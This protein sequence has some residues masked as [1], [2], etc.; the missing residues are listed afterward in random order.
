MASTRTAALGDAIEQR[1]RELDVE[2]RADALVASLA[3]ARDRVQE[4]SAELGRRT[5][6]SSR[7]SA[8]SARVALEQ[9][10]AAAW[11]LPDRGDDLAELTRRAGERL[12]RERTKAGRRA[13]RRRRNRLVLIGGGLAGAGLLVGWLTA[14]RRGPAAGQLGRLR[15]TPRTPLDFQT[16]PV[17]VPQDV[18]V[19]PGNGSHPDGPRSD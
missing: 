5:S 3:T 11:Q 8:E 6:R 18:V 13:A 14:P 7:R 15:G 4:L 17:G 10:R 12:F 19:A 16:G 9:A 1:L 2:E